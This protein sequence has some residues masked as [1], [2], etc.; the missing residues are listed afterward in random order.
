MTTPKTHGH[1]G[2][3]DGGE[4]PKSK[5]HMAETPESVQAF[6]DAI[7][8]IAPGV[9]KLVDAGMGGQAAGELALEI[10]KETCCK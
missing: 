6:E 4:A 7:D 10:F 5:K 2:T 3:D 8:A 9:K 1:A